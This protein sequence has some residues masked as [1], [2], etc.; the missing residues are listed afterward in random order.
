[1]PYLCSYMMQVCRRF[2]LLVLAFSAVKSSFA[3]SN[4]YVEEPG[5]FTG[6]PVFGLNLAQVD[7]D[8]YFGYNKAGISAGVFVRIHYTSRLSTGVEILYSQK[9]SR[10]EAVLSSSYMGT[11]IATCHIGLNYVEVPVTMQYTY[12]SFNAE[13][14]LSY[15]RLVK[16]DEWI[17]VDPPVAID[18][19]KNRFNN[20]DINYVFGLSRKVYKNLVANIRFQYSMISIRPI[21]RVPYGYAYG[22]KGQFNNLFSLRLMY[23]LK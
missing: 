4:F 17:L 13:A 6:G 8:Q 15:S 5:V 23:E 11:Y 7:G 14:G 19:V 3:Q 9:G 1:M 22:T 16:T 12:A 2:F 20:T 10:G 18:N 21:E